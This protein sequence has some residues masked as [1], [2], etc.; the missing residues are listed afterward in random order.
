E[1]GIEGLT[2][3]QQEKQSVHFQHILYLLGIGLLVSSLSS[4]AGDHLPEIGAD[5]N[6]TTWTI[7]IA[8]IVGLVLGQTKVSRIP[9]AIDVSNIML[10]IIVA[11]F[12]SIY[13]FSQIA[14]ASFQ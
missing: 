4:F 13:A 6:G 1:K 9:G 7:I 2:D 12:A 5:F 14:L 10:Y 8:S 3:E 11:L